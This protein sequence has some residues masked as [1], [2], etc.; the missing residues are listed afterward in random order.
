MR[1]TKLNKVDQ[2][3]DLYHFI[4]WSNLYIKYWIINWLLISI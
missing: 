4:L 2:N 3:Y 1:Q